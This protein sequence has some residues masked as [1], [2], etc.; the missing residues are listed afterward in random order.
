MQVILFFAGM[1]LLVWGIRKLGAPWRKYHEEHI[2]P[3]EKELASAKARRTEKERTR[4]QS[5]ANAELFIRDF[6]AEVLRHQ[7][8]KSA[9][10]DKLKPLQK[11][12]SELHEEQKDVRSEL[13]SWH[14][15]SKSFFGNEGKKIK[16]DS[17]LGWLGLEQT[18][19]QK[20]SLESRRASISSEIMD[21]KAE[22][23]AIYE[24]QINPAKNGIK[25][26]FDD[27]KVLKRF[28][29]DGLNEPHFRAEG[30]HLELEI[31]DINSKISHLKEMIST[32]T[33]SY[34]N[35]RRL[36]TG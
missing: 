15:S 13:D 24:R 19:A 16:D 30:K 5:I 9:A 21:L 10:H 25:A 27:Q 4:N 23:S 12:K 29:Q 11:R 3:L 20:E 7:K 33:E 36:R 31:A 8:A 1:A 22:M 32:A 35:Q 17:I 18:V 28:R 26:A 34:K 14:R 2:S 6:R